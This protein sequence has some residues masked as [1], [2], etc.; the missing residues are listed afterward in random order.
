[1]TGLTG[2]NPHC[3]S[4]LPLRV[5]VGWQPQAQR[6][7]RGFRGCTRVSQDEASQRVLQVEGTGGQENTKF[8]SW[9]YPTGETQK[10]SFG[11]NSEGAYML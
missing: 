4:P 10:I 9:E 7:L 3:S 1:M 2:H 5:H 6:Q 11:T 8:G